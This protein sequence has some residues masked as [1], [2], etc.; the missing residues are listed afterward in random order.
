MTYEAYLC[1]LAFLAILLCAC[2]KNSEELFDDTPD[3]PINKDEHQ[4]PKAELIDMGFLLVHLFA[5]V[6]VRTA[7]AR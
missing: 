7:G 5:L 2:T 6:S 1:K 4:Y 3:T